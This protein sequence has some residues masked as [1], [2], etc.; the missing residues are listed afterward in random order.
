MRIRTRE[1][2]TLRVTDEPSAPGRD[3]PESQRP[4]RGMAA[5][6]RAASWTIDWYSNQHRGITWS[7]KG[8]EAEGWLLGSLVGDG[9]F[10]SKLGRADQVLTMAHMEFWGQNRE[11]VASQRSHA[12]WQRGR[13]PCRLRRP[14]RCWLEQVPTVVG[15]VWRAWLPNTGSSLATRHVTPAV[16]ATS[17]DFHR[18]FLRGLFD[19]D[20]SVQGTQLK[21]VSVRLS[22]SNLATLEAAQRML[23]RL[24]IASD[25]LSRTGVP[26]GTDSY[27]TADGG[28][29][30]YWTQAQHELVVADDN[31]Q[32]FATV[33]RIFGS[34]QIRKT[35]RGHRWLPP[36]SQSRAIYRDDREHRARRH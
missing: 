27:P 8:T 29:A 21:G 36:Y 16:E 10:S 15:R 30:A 11:L 2:Y 34:R 32:E 18:G 35:R 7:G 12:T 26:L 20:G 28:T 3:P 25:D 14:V 13:D 23:L 9:T 31:V 17:S 19:A 1:G 24:G 33:R 5:R 6:R 22:Q 4:A